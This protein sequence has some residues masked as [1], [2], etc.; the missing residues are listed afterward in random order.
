MNSKK[1]T[2]TLNFKPVRVITDPCIARKQSK[3]PRKS[4]SKE[5]SKPVPRTA[6]K[7]RGRSPVK[8]VL[9]VPTLPKRK[10]STNKNSNPRSQSP[11]LSPARSI[12]L[13]SVSENDSVFETSFTRG[14][15]DLA[16]NRWSF[17]PNPQPTQS[18]IV[19]N[20]SRH[21][22][23]DDEEKSLKLALSKSNKSFQNSLNRMK[24]R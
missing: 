20:N 18:A 10:S 23:E 6:K 13:S 4:K 21:M 1:S 16:T 17:S 5:V 14:G 12:S 11:L 22:I 15:F 9:K 7:E 8:K 2:D 19:R 24:K 3:T